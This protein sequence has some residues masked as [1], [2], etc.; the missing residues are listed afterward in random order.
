MMRVILIGSGIAGLTAAIGLR[1]VGID[2]AVYER[3]PELREV[4]AGISLWANAIR[5]VAL[6]MDQSEFRADEGRLLQVQL[7]GASFEKKIGV[8]PFVAMAHRAELVGALAGFLAEGVAR[9]GFECVGVE[10][11]GERV[12]VR[13]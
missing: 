6:S 13:F 12:A 10:Q 9:Y 8:S 1:K 4:G 3:A 11:E 7:S 2:V 5:A